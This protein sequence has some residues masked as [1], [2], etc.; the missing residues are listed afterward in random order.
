MEGGADI[1]PGAEENNL[2][3]ENMISI[4]KVIADVLGLLLNSE[5]SE[6]I[7]KALVA[8][9]NF[10]DADR[11]YILLY[12]WEKYIM[13]LE[14][15]VTRD[16][17]FTLKEELQHSTPD[18]FPWWFD[19]IVHGKDIVVPD[20]ENMPP[21]AWSERNILLLQEVRSLIA[22]PLFSKGKVVASLGLDAVRKKR[23]WTELEK[24]SL[25]LLGD[26]ISIAVER[27]QA[28]EE[29]Q[30]SRNLLQK[31]EEKYRQKALQSEELLT[32]LKFVVGINDSLMW[33]Y[34]VKADRLNVQ[35]ELLG[36]PKTSDSHFSL[37]L[38]PFATKQDFYNA[39]YPADR[40]AVFHDHFERLLRGEIAHYTISYR[41]LSTHGYIWVYASVRTYKWDAEGKPEK[42]IYYLTNAQE[43]VQ[44][45]KK[46]D[47][48][49]AMMK[50]ILNNV[51]V[52]VMV[53]DV[54]DRFRYLYFNG[55]AENF[56]GLKAEQV[57]GR[58]DEEIYPDREYAK[59]LRELDRKAVKTG[60]YS[61]YAQEHIFLSGEKKT[62]NSMRVVIDGGADDVDKKVLLITL[63]WDITKERS[64]EVALIQAQEA[65]KLKSAFLA[66]MSHEIRTP[67]NAIVGFSSVMAETD[68]RKERESFMSIIRSNNDLL[69]Q[70]MNDILDFSKIDS[71]NLNYILKEVNLKDICV[72]VGR[73]YSFK[74]PE[75]V[76]LVC[77]LDRL[78]D[79]VLYTDA[80]RVKQVLS[81]LLSN[82][83]KF[84]AEGTV[85]LFYEVHGK[86]IRISVSDTGQGVPEDKCADIFQCFVK[87]DDFKQGTGLGLPISKMIVEKLGG[88][89][90]VRSKEG[91][92][93]VFWFTLPLSVPSGDSP[94]T[95][96]QGK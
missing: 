30:N 40:Q 76:E 37:K 75:R 88:A 86:N 94:Y 84:T 16:R 90:G 23:S 67:L 10:F 91:K 61:R 82:A 5:T 42:V 2:L 27:R 73:I 4:R 87:L 26:I 32:R 92:G 64:N 62:I 59:Y 20:V 79:V 85:R 63:I 78:P 28:Q 22:L 31:S 46:I 48:L 95:L 47:S 93:S 56:T 69:L 80:E 50:I 74:L 77:E 71:G 6:A 51:P 17:L 18:D 45:Q 83:I 11:A 52:V 13:S 7:D 81:N 12:D 19:R 44:Q 39:I 9:L 68:D 96:K 55:A 15:E 34:D 3:L 43:Q 41:R 57:V 89:I 24:E 14:H 33:E 35:L 58:T 1:R 8:I 66:N 29:V 60:T 54:T 72:E 70:L 65:D 21:E 53:K 36:D 38:N 25:R 49:N